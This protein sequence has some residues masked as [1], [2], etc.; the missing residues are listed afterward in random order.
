MHRV[1]FMHLDFDSAGRSL[2]ARLS[3]CGPS[4]RGGADTFRGRFPYK[5]PLHTQ[6]NAGRT[7]VGAVPEG[8]T[9]AAGFPGHGG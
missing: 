4:T 2:Q 1:E 5:A 6:K 9:Q 8:P 3:R 7:S